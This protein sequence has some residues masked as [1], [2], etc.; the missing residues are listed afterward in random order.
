MRP[1]GSTQDFHGSDFLSGLGDVSDLESGKKTSASKKME[2]EKEKAKLDKEFAELDESTS[3]PAGGGTGGRL[4][5]KF[6]NKKLEQA[7]QAREAER[8]SVNLGDKEP[9]VLEGWLEQKVGGGGIMSKA[10]YERKF[11]RYTLLQR[12]HRSSHHADNP[13]P[14]LPH[15]DLSCHC[16]NQSSEAASGVRRDDERYQR[17]RRRLE[18]DSGKGHQMG[19]GEIHDGL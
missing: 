7:E 5:A 3:E 19:R 11:F 12:T 15:F 14:A 10:K 13:N 16:Q 9:K 2:K 18:L 8:A 17:L 1:L 4:V 6:A